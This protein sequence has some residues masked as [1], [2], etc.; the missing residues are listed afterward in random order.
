MRVSIISGLSAGF[1]QLLVADVDMLSCGG[2]FSGNWSQVD[3]APNNLEEPTTVEVFARVHDRSLAS[4]FSE[5]H[6]GR[7]CSRL[8]HGTR[9]LLFHSSLPVIRP[10]W[11]LPSEYYL[12]FFT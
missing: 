9:S 11:A 6:R 8:N 10:I 2:G 5:G 7:L 3:R 12:L 4:P 1:S